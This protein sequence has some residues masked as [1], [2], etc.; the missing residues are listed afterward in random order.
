MRVLSPAKI[1]L[2]LRVGPKRS[3]GFHP[4]VS[5]MVTV[6]LF[7]TLD[8]TLDTAGRVGLSC[9]DPTLATDESNLVVRAARLIQAEAMR[10][11]GGETSLSTDA[12]RCGV[13][14]ELRKAIPMGGGLGGGSSNAASTLMALNELWKLN[15]P[16]ERLSEMASALGSDVPF[17]LNG[18][19]GIC[20]GRGEIVSR[21]DP[22][23]ARWVVLLL[24]EMSMPTAEVYRRFDQMPA[25]PGWDEA[26]EWSQWRT[27][28][29]EDL[30][31]A[32]RNDLEPPAS[33]IS[34]ELGTLRDAAEVLV[35]RPVRMSGSGSTLFTLFDTKERAQQAVFIIQR[36][37]GVRTM[38]VP[39]AAFEEV[40]G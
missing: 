1:N 9:S 15:L 7:D 24:P 33:A 21:V 31:R 17:F 3:D 34:P 20:T 37:L 39:I 10:S 26:V 6:G 27:L 38:T 18:P 29:A 40:S 28:L 23:R 13:R 14:I 11:C 25:L 22:P 4:L 8:F 5:W 36:D 12:G 2:H 32:L 30:L 19:S 35:S 16:R